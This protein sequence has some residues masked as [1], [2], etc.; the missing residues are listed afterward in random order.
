MKFRLWFTLLL[1]FVWMWPVD[2]SVEA[3]ATARIQ[4]YL[5]GVNLN[6]DSPPYI[7]PK[8]NVTMVPL[9][10]I[11]EGLQANVEWS[12]QTK[13]VKVSKDGNLI[14]LRNGDKM[15]EV[16][17]HSV[18]LDATAESKQGRTMVPLRFISEELNLKV[19][20]NQEKQS[21]TLT[22]VQAGE[23]TQ[24]P[25]DNGT[26]DEL[27]GVWVSTVSN[28]DWPSKSTYNN[29]EAQ[30]AEYI[31]LLDDLQGMGMN[32]V[33]LQVRPSADAIYSSRLVP[34][35]T[36]LTGTPGKDPGY[37]PLEFL[38]EETH[39]RG[40]E[41]HAWF[42]PFRAS[43]GSDASK[44]P[45]NHVAN[46]HPDWIVKHGGKMYINPGIPEA[47]AHIIEVIMEVVKY[48]DIDGVHLDDYFYP[49]G[50]TASS[51]FNDDVTY[52]QYNKGAYKNKGDWRRGNINEFVEELGR[53][54]VQADPHI[55]F[56]ISPYGVW[57]NQSKD[58]TGSDTK[59]SVTAYDSTY[60]DVRAWIK[61]EWIDYVIPQIYWSLSRQEV[62]Y[63][64]LANWWSNEVRGTDVKLYIGHSP[65]KIGTPEIGW[66]S[67]EEII[68][69]LRYN[70][71]I[72]EIKGSVFFSAKDLRKN[73]LGLIQRLQAF[74]VTD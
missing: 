51:K 45:A 68:R 22:S 44:L 14:V 74:Y 20:W 26:D 36:Y 15:A 61:H 59:A 40:M 24:T 73:P 5:D 7:K 58:L 31:K 39:K 28:L 27:R 65:Y 13:Q 52:Q 11:S 8:V 23:E 62:R 60:A 43:T 57:R 70:R 35:S 41:F 19:N 37:D 47:R 50:E 10:V 34:W 69:Q 66:D 2:G 72:P 64:I 33:F 30:K 1:L 67:A 3:A 6:S 54:I 29:P 4:I 42:N 55:S 49:T 16:N 18:V 9:R 38:I 17:G 32:T 48:Y 63:D 25:D 12:N 71:T 56:G 53:S 21:I 46:E